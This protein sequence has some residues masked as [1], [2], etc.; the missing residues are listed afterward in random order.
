MESTTLTDE[1][2]IY[3]GTYAKYNEGNL[4]GAWLKLEDY[5]DHDAFYEAA[6]ELHSDESDPE[7]MFQDWQCIPSHYIGESHLDAKAWDWLELDEDDREIVHLYQAEVGYGDDEPSTA[8]EAYAGTY[9]SEE[10]WA[11][12]QVDDL[13]TSAPDI[14]KNYFDYEAYARDCRL[15]GDITFVHHQG[16]VIAF[17]N[18]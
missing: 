14:L 3:V 5:P 17:T 10:D 8:L 1:P 7:L 4:H 11:A 6:R 12:E 13:L 9:N 18:R 15:N 2:A 16:D